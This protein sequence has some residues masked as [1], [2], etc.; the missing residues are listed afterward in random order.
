MK[1]VPMLSTTV[2]YIFVKLTRCWKGGGKK[3]VFGECD[4]GTVFGHWTRGVAL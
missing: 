3:S 4:S 2:K 1:T